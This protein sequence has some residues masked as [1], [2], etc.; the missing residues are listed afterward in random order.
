MGEDWA[1]PG[2]TYGMPW[3]RT[4]TGRQFVVGVSLGHTLTDFIGSHPCSEKMGCDMTDV[5]TGRI[6]EGG[7]LTDVNTGRIPEGGY[8]DGLH[9]VPSL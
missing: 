8:L 3:G 6:P 9:R 1:I 2:A 4:T 7:A 5:N